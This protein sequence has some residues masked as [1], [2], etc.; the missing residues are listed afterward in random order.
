M[1][2]PEVALDKWKGILWAPTTTDDVLALCPE[3]KVRLEIQTQYGRSAQDAP[4]T[5]KHQYLV[6][7]EDNVF[8][9]MGGVQFWMFKRRYNSAKEAISLKNVRIFDLDNVY[10]PVLKKE[11]KP[12]DKDLSLQVEIDKVPG[13]K[14]IVIYAADR[15]EIDKKTQIFIDPQKESATFDGNDIHPNSIFAKVEITY[16][17][18]KKTT[19]EG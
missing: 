18:G 10:T 4:S 2:T 8:F 11:P 3:H 1:E 6:C 15:N 12:K 17:S 16:K 19:L 7:P 14:K 5:V 13:G 9:P